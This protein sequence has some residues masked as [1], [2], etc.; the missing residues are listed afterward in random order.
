MEEEFITPDDIFK[1]LGKLYSKLGSKLWALQRMYN[2]SKKAQERKDN[3][4]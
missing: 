2:K 1:E 4:K 3:E